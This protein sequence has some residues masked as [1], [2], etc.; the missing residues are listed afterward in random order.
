MLNDGEVVE[1]LD[2]GAEREADVAAVDSGLLVIAGGIPVNCSTM[3][4]KLEGSVFTTVVGTRRDGLIR[5]FFTFTAPVP[6]GKP[7]TAAAPPAATARPVD[8][9]EEYL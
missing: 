2:C 6:R 7:P 9:A 4:L 3:A 1:L 5:F 8:N